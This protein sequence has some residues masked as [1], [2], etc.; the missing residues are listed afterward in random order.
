MFERRYEEQRSSSALCKLCGP[1]RWHALS[2]DGNI[3]CGSVE[4]ICTT[5]IPPRIFRTELDEVSI[6]FGNEMFIERSNL[7]PSKS[8]E[9]IYE[10]RAKKKS[11]LIYNPRYKVNTLTAMSRNCRER[12]RRNFDQECWWSISIENFDW[13]FW[14]NF[15][16]ENIAADFLQ[17]ILID[18]YS[19]P[20]V[21]MKKVSHGITKFARKPVS[22][23]TPRDLYDKGYPTVRE[24]WII[25]GKVS[26]PRAATSPSRIPI[27]TNGPWLTMCKRWSWIHTVV[28]QRGTDDRLL[29]II[30]KPSAKPKLAGKWI[31]PKI[32]A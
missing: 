20:F 25:C 11:H 1:P 13:Q 9:W 17:L 27:R 7:F 19:V 22:S 26:A 2:R 30:I 18:N 21:S 24:R 3:F 10:T 8:I 32:I 5:R 12:K 14:L 16:N 15:L 31:E 4:S 6:G 28:G 29:P 23:R